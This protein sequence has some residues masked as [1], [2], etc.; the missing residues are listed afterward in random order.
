MTMKIEFEF[1]ALQSLNTFNTQFLSFDINHR[2]GYERLKTILH[3]YFLSQRKSCF[4]SFQK[5]MESSNS[6]SSC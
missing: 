1:L 3:F 2:L 5:A 6:W 4:F